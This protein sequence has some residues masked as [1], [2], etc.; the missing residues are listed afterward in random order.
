LPDKVDVELNRKKYTATIVSIESF[1]V[2]LALKD[3]LGN[4]IEHCNPRLALVLAGRIAV[5]AD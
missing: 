3:F 4:K 1:N 5:T 2:I